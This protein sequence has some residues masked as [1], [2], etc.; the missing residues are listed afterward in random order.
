M[1]RKTE[2][3]APLEMGLMISKSLID[4]GVVLDRGAT[5]GKR[6]ESGVPEMEAVGLMIGCAV[7]CLRWDLRVVPS[8]GETMGDRG[9]VISN[10]GSRFWGERRARM[11]MLEMGSFRSKGGGCSS[12][13]EATIGAA[14]AKG[15]EIEE[16]VEHRVW[17]VLVCDCQ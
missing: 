15:E 2:P 16:G 9:G 12:G 11:V 8:W 17:W 7:E 6:G 10:L 14:R 3:N 5:E 4:V 1:A 13:C